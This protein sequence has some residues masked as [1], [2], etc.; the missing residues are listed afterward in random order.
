MT[1]WKKERPILSRER[2][3]ERERE[4]GGERD[5]MCNPTYSPLFF[6]DDMVGQ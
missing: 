5:Y 4:G 6:D 2:E 1:G 3:R